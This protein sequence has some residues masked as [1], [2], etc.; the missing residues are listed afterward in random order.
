MVYCGYRE[1]PVVK[2]FAENNKLPT[3]NLLITL[4]TF[5]FSYIIRTIVELIVLFHA[6]TIANFQ[7]N[8]CTN[9]NDGWAIFVFF[10]HLFGEVFPL[11]MM[12]WMQ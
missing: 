5:T 9:G 11:S 7:V 3:V 10:Y 4:V 12:F 6:A 8:S 1:Y 2:Q